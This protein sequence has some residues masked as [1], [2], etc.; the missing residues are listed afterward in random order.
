MRPFALVI[1]LLAVVAASLSL[2]LIWP[3]AEASSDATLQV[4]AGGQ[5]TCGV[6]TDGTLACWGQNDYG[7]A[8]PPTSTTLLTL[9]TTATSTA[10]PTPTAPA[11]VTAKPPASATPMLTSSVTPT[12]TPTPRPTAAVPGGLPL[13]VEA[14]VARYDGPAD[15]EGDNATALAVDEKGNVYVTGNSD[16][17]LATIKY[18]PDGTE[19]WVARHRGGYSSPA[20]AVDGQGNVYVAGPLEADYVTIKYQ[21]DGSQEWDAIFDG[22]GHGWDTPSALALDEAGNVYVTGTSPGSG[23]QEDYATIK[24]SPDGTQLWIA[25]YDGPTSERDLAT[26]LALDAAGNVYVTGYS[27]GV[28]DVDLDCATVKYAPDGAEVWVARYDG[29][30]GGEDRARAMAVDEGGNVYVAGS[31]TGSDSREYYATIKYAPDGAQLWVARYDGPNGPPGQVNGVAVDQEGDVY[32]TGYSGCGSSYDSGTGG[33]YA[34]I[35]Y[36]ASGNQ[37]WVACYDGAGL[38]D[39]PTALAV[40]SEGNAYVTGSSYADGLFPNSEYSEYATIKYGPDGTQIWVARYRATVS[41]A[42]SP[43]WPFALALDSQGNVYVAGGSLGDYATVKYVQ[44]VAPT[45]AATPSPGLTPGPPKAP[46]T[47]IG[48][49]SSDGNPDWWPII[50]LA[51]AALCGFGGLTVWPRRG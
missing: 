30:A 19:L 1:F 4:S 45:P 12:F 3:T 47:G 43:T 42:P 46:P 5:H 10:A 7:Q 44:K 16:G 20:L 35:K 50:L 17:H 29:P 37:V 33:D 8:T 49:D 51:A 9:T 40:D 25:R 28:Y 34:T 41:D 14:W 48:A 15:G 26:S 11:T 2:V 22:P 21:A 23:S 13:A 27:G 32:V 36:D 18:A 31:S 39:F 6:R 24:Y 38:D